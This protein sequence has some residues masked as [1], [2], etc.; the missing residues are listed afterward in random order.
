MNKRIFHE[1]NANDI[2]EPTNDFSMPAGDILMPSAILSQY[3]E[4]AK[5]RERRR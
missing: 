2:E 1:R 3:G 5:W 4:V